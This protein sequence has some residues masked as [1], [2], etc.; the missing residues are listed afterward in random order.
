MASRAGKE[1]AEFVCGPRLYLA[2]LD[3]GELPLT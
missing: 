1:R 3:S 2:A